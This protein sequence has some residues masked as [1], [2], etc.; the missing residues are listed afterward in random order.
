MAL[1]EYV[2]STLDELL[3]RYINGVNDKNNSIKDDFVKDSLD[4]D[5]ETYSEIIGGMKDFSYQ[6]R[7]QL[8][9]NVNR[10][11][12]RTL[13]SFVRKALRY[14]KSPSQLYEKIS[15]IYDQEVFNKGDE[16]LVMILSKIYWEALKTL[17]EPD[18]IR[19]QKYYASREAKENAE[20]IKYIVGELLKK[21]LYK[22]WS[23]MREDI[24]ENEIMDDLKEQARPFYGQ[25]E[26]VKGKIE[27][28]TPYAEV[29]NSID[30]LVMELESNYLQFIQGSILAAYK[31]RSAP[32]HIVN[33]LKYLV[34]KDFLKNVF[35]EMYNESRNYINQL[36]PAGQQPNA[37]PPQP[38][39]PG[40]PGNQ[41]NIPP[42]Q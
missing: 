27:K 42:Q 11:L 4:A 24:D 38:P 40:Q 36:Q 16:G 30:K 7:G 34:G 31:R 10:D 41:S 23:A 28:L 25:W 18:P 1:A 37:Q 9:P 13:R 32:E 19:G 33:V 17:G 14:N 35:K 6:F 5:T 15:D 8:D 3:K 29:R 12:K 26:A 39:Q 20:K 22:Y 21:A 2:N